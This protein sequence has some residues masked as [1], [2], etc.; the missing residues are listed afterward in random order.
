MKI[1][2]CLIL[3]YVVLSF[4]CQSNGNDS[5]RKDPVSII[6]TIKRGSYFKNQGNIDHISFRI[7]EATTDSLITH[8]VNGVTYKVRFEIPRLDYL[9]ILADVSN[10]GSLEEEGEFFL[11]KVNKT[12]STNYMEIG[13]EADLK[14]DSILLQHRTWSDST[15]SNYVDSFRGFIPSGYYRISIKENQIR[16]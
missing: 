14:G 7:Y 3:I 9:D 10:N 2:I 6:D 1:S 5:S 13:F 4:S 16:S 12:D 11:L 8:L 15:K